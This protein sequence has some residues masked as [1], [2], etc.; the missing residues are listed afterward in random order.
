LKAGVEEEEGEDFAG[1]SVQPLAAAVLES[2][3]KDE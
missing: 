3:V 1:G 2:G